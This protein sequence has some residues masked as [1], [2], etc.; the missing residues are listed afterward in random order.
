[1][2]EGY[3]EALDLIYSVIYK[4]DLIY[5]VLDCVGNLQCGFEQLSQGSQ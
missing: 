4:L 5:S 2:V 3:R 1:M